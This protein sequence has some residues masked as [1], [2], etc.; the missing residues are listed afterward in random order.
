MPTHDQG[1]EEPCNQRVNPEIHTTTV[2]NSYIN[3]AI[4]L[5]RDE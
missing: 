2:C 4:S 5:S 3:M 1:D